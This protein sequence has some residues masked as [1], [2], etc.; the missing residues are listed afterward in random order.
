VERESAAEFVSVIMEELKPKYK[1]FPE[2]PYKTIVGLVSPVSMD[3][4][5]KHWKEI[6]KSVYGHVILED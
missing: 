1:F 4:V 6:F 2:N 3:A 5:A